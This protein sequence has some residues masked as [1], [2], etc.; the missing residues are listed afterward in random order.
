MPHPVSEAAL[1]LLGGAVLDALIG[2]PVTPAHPVRWIGRSISAGEWGLRRL[3]LSGRIGGIL[4]VSWMHGLSQ[5]VFWGAWLLLG[6]LHPWAAWGL[7]TVT[8]WAC[9][10]LRDLMVHARRVQVAL[11]AQDLPAGR[12]AVSMLVGRDVARLD[13]AGVA[14]ATVESV[15]ESL[16]DAWWGPVLWFGLA[17]LAAPWT[18]GPAAGLAAATILAYRVANTADSMVGHKDDRYR[19]FGWASARL[20]DLLGL[21]PARTCP[22]ILVPAAVLTGAE[23]LAGWRTFWRDRLHHASPNAGHP[24][25]FAAGALRLS[26]GGPTWYDDGCVEKPWL[27]EGSRQAAPVH[28]GRACWLI[29]LAAWLG[30]LGI[31]GLLIVR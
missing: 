5:S 29:G 6:R 8:V 22:L 24:E 28:I 10:A 3:G 31:V 25:A 12:Q 21:L 13:E 2:D 17:A 15:A 16:V 9:I 1:V 19:Y 27:G 30:V 11:Q 4:L 18:G 20:D 14:R 7:A 23:V 26:L